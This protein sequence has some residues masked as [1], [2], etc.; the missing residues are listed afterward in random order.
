M[1]HLVATNIIIWAMTVI[2]EGA[3]TY[4]HH[5]YNDVTTLPSD[6][7]TDVTQSELNTTSGYTTVPASDVTLN[8]TAAP[9]T[10]QTC[11]YAPYS[12]SFIRIWQNSYM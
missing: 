8:T 11:M 9:G 3:N 7:M 10:E 2:M 5:I 12:D 6:V 1:L 4:V